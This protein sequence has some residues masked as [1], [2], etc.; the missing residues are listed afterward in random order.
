MLDVIRLAR[1]FSAISCR[2]WMYFITD[3]FENY[4]VHA[5]HLRNTAFNTRDT[6]DWDVVSDFDAV[7]EALFETLVLG[8]IPNLG[9]QI[10]SNWEKNNAFLIHASGGGFRV[11]MSPTK[12]ACG[13]WDH[14]IDTL[15]KHD[16]QIAFLNYFDWD[17]HGTIDFRYYYG[18]VIQSD[19]YPDIIDHHLLIPTD[20]AE[21]YVNPLV[22]KKPTVE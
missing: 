15:M 17:E 10:A 5:R 18:V 8:R 19:K 4:R 20:S 13:S 12:G 7:D 14:D 3:I 21:I 2:A 11:M 16:A 22:A 6:R 9:H 1:T